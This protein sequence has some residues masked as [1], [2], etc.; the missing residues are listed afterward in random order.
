[1]MPSLPALIR[2]LLR[3]TLVLLP[4]CAQAQELPVLTLSVLQ[5]GTPHW[6]LEHLKRQQ[7]DRANG[8]ELRVRLVADVPASRLA[9][10]S[11]TAR[12]LMCRASSPSSPVSVS[13]SLV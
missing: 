11:P 9:L 8:F 6:E 13:G 2:S 12:L 10:S 5:F 7:L 1:M 3:L 4:L